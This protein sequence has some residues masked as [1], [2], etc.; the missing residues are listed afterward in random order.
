MRFEI[1]DA[2]ADDQVRLHA[3]HH[4]AT[5]SSYGRELG[6]LDPILA[7]S[8]TPLETVEW[9]IVAADPGS[10][11]GYA[12]VTANHLENLYVDPAA[13]G[14]GVGSALLGAVETRLR[15][16]FTRVTLR[17][18]HTNPD[19]R[20]LYERQGYSVQEDQTVVL[21]GRPLGAWLMAKPLPWA[22]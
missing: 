9:T 13:Q 2:R 3:I 10:V 8:A 6:W 19:A 1:R 14:R 22:P 20:R 16:R 21:H 4:R 18:L 12:A 11:L 7:D 5:M 15:D 17:C